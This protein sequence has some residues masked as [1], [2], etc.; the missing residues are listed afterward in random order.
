MYNVVGSGAR[1]SFE[2]TVGLREG[3]GDHGKTHTLAE[4]EDLAVE[5]LK[6]RAAEGRPFLPGT[7]F[8]GEVCYAWSGKIPDEAGGGHEPVAQY[9]GEVN[10]LYSADMT[11]EEAKRILMD[12]VSFLGRRLGQVRVYLVYRDEV[13]ILQQEEKATPT[14]E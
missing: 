13:F 1:R 5:W 8:L 3:Y 10:P 4:A 2:L 7:F 6:A 12:L 11:D 14:G 9:R